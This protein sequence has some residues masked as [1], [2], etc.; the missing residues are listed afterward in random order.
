[1][2]HHLVV[3]GASAGGIKALIELFKQLP[4]NFNAAILVVL[5]ISNNPDN[6]LT[7]ILSKHSA[8]PVVI[9]TDLQEVKPGV[10]YVAPPSVH[11]SL[12][13]GKIALRFGPKINHSRPAIDPLFY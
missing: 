4:A 2:T 12:V 11:M 6:V 7:K 10:I 5:H 3:I 9:P 13:N 8:L 1:M